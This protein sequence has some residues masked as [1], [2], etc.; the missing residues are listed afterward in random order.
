MRQLVGALLFFVL[1]V[2]V[3]LPAL[4]VRG[5]D[6]LLPRGRAPAEPAAEPVVSLY[7]NASG[8]LLELP[9]EQYV[10]GVVAAEMP[11]AFS[12][13]ALKAQAVVAR[14]YV[15][16]RL[17]SLGGAGCD[18]A[19]GADICDDP[20]HGQ[21]WASWAEMRRRWGFWGFFPAYARVRRAVEATRGLVVAYQGQPVDPLYHSTCAGATEDAAWVWGAPQPWLRSVP[22]SWDRHSPFY[23]TQV[24]FSAPDLARLLEGQQPQPPS[25]ASGGSRPAGS[26][27]AAPSG[28]PAGSAAPLAAGAPHGGASSPA[29]ATAPKLEILGRSPTGRVLKVRVDGRE[30]TGTEVR[31]LLGLR[32]T[33]F[34]ISQAAGGGVTFTVMGWGH[35]VGMCQYGADGMAR[36]GRDFSEII[37]YYYSGAEAVAFSSLGWR[38]TA[39]K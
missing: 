22:C 34:D 37:R 33:R 18:R 21:A 20:A 39:G 6:L 4:V 7:V 38:A 29:G 1:L 35:G 12:L 14:T 5:C 3:V 31:A 32:S 13:E 17:R 16:K 23:Q 30:L 8:R 19:E 2:V 15:L 11:S 25:P 26:A 10:M 9:L 24:T 27:P 28:P 36:A